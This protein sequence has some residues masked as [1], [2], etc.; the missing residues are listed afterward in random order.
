MWS[1][2][3]FGFYCSILAAAATMGCDDASAVVQPVAFNHEIHVRENEME[4]SDCHR[5]VRT[6]RA[7]GRPSVRVCEDCHDVMLGDSDEERRV[8]EYVEDRR[9]IPWRRLFRLDHSVLFSHARHVTVAGIECQSC[10][11][12]MS[13]RRTPPRAALM[14]IGMNDCIGCHRTMQIRDDCNACHR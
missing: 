11:G 6:S 7:A 13:E 4:C 5:G 1:N 10:H 9:E 3:S 2:V 14:R 8:V 12:A